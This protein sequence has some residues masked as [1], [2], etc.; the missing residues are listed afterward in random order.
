MGNLASKSG[1]LLKKS[2]HLTCS[3]C[4]YC[5]YYW[6][7]TW[8]CSGDSGSWSGVGS[9]NHECDSSAPVNPLTLVAQP[10][11]SW[12]KWSTTGSTCTY[13]Y[14]H[15]GGI[16]TTDGDCTDTPSAPDS[17]PSSHADCNCPTCTACQS[18][19]DR[20]ANCASTYTLVASGF[21]TGCCNGAN[22]TWTLSH[23]VP[24][25]GDYGRDCPWV[26]STWE[27][28]DGLFG[29]WTLTC[30]AITCGGV[31][32]QNWIVSIELCFDSGCTAIDAGT[33]LYYQ[34]VTHCCPPGTYVDCTD[35]A[36]GGTCLSGGTIIVS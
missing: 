28:D 1:H 21:S 6:E 29:R 3:C 24:G 11:D 23:P 35:S 34:H 22:G 19:S 13:R 4:D 16:C 15:K 36:D 12:H 27:C 10:M 9:I 2:G 25:D 32:S 14:Y 18:C 33:G 26:S 7:C 5:Y 8:T 17:C 31:L 30:A 20:V